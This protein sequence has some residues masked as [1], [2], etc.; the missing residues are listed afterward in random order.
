MRIAALTL[1]MTPWGI[2]EASETAWFYEAVGAVLLLLKTN[3]FMQ[4]FYLPGQHNLFNILSLHS[5]T[6]R[7]N[8][9][10]NQ[11]SRR[12]CEPVEPTCW[13]FKLVWQSVTPA[14]VFFFCDYNKETRI[15]LTIYQKCFTS[16]EESR[17]FGKLAGCIGTQL[18]S[19]KIKGCISAALSF[20]PHFTLQIPN[21]KMA[22]PRFFA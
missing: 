12:H 2:G 11:S 5:L 15:F 8:N 19:S 17:G 10:V 1:A 16:P 21:S 20:A 9:G 14:I 6:I 3:C 22:H 13:L 7:L 18:L 4:F